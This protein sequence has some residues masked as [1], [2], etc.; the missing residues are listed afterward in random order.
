MSE[1]CCAVPPS[2]SVA[3]ICPETTRATRPVERFTVQHHAL[4]AL[5]GQVRNAA[6]GFCDEPT[7][8]IVY[9]G[10]QG[11]LLRKVDLRTRVGIK[12]TED[13]ITVCYCWSY[14][15]RQVQ[16]D[17]LANAQST[18]IPYITQRVK[19]GACACEI[20]NPSGRCCLGE[21]TKAVLQ[22][23]RRRAEPAILPGPV[24][25]EE[26]PACPACGDPLE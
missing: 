1:H 23:T 7:C 18:V 19:E 2:H 21:V 20:N 8:E 11:H 16:E 9:V 22:V 15:A 14:T 17:V 6:Y 3:P 12:E 13:P 4:P 25:A 24:G 10:D 26:P 5:V